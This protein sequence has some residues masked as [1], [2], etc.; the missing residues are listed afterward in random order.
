MS[1]LDEETIAAFAETR[2]PPDGIARLE[3]HVRDCG[4][5][6]SLVSLALAATPDR[7]VAGRGAAPASGA[8]A[9]HPP[10]PAVPAAASGG[11]L[12][13]GTAVGRYTVLE[14]VGRGGMGEVYAAYDPELD[15]KIALKIL[16]SDAEAD[17]TRGGSRLLREAKAIAKLHHPNV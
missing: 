8:P 14:L 15:R 3:A 10:P 1:C 2:L 5:C 4:S 16:N 9:V 6:R 12:A 13:R 17:D 7:S 11:P